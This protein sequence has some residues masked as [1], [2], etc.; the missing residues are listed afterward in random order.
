MGSK[1]ES[2][3][4]MNSDNLLAVEQASEKEQY[5]LAI[6][7]LGLNPETERVIKQLLLKR[8]PRK[9]AGRTDTTSFQDF[10]CSCKKARRNVNNN[11]KNDDGPTSSVSTL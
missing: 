7:L 1:S 3:D 4:I 10:S 5:K 2:K 6:E 11:K 9:S 8:L